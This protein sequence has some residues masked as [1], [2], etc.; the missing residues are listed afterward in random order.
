MHACLQ[1][2]RSAA[3]ENSARLVD[4]QLGGVVA[5]AAQDLQHGRDEAAV[6]HRLGQLD[7]PKVARRVLLVRAVRGALDRAVHGAQ[8]RVGQAVELGAAALI[9]LAHVDLGHGVA[10][11]RARAGSEEV[12]ASYRGRQQFIS[13]LILNASTAVTLLGGSRSSQRQTNSPTAQ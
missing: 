9:R 11:L 7:V 3:A 1:Q 8:A 10:P 2:V 6:V 4:E 13:K 12:R 5:D